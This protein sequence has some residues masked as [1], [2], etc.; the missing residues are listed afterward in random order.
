MAFAYRRAEYEQHPLFDVFSLG[1][2]MRD[3]FEDGLPHLLPNLEAL[4]SY[5][6][7]RCEEVDPMDRLT[8]Q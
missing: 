8:F 4:I 1:R 5:I 6:I 7:E 3:I 2:V